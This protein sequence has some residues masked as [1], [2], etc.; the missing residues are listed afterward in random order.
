MPTQQEIT[1]CLK[2]WRDNPLQFH[3]SL[4]DRILW[5]KQVEVIES[6]RD[7]PRTVVKSG[8]TVGKTHISAEIVLWFLSTHY[9]AKVITTAPTWTQVE[10]ILWKEIASMYHKAKV[11]FGGDLLKTELKLSDDW[12][13]LGVST[14]EVN[15]FQGFHS[16]YLLVVIDEALGV[17]PMI[18]EAIEGLHPYRILAIGNP[19]EGVGNFYN[20]FQS[21][22]W[23]KITI[24]CEECVRWQKEN[25]VI[26]GLVTQVWIN[27]RAEDWG[28]GSPLFQSRVSGEF[29]EETAS[30]LISRAWIERAR[31]GLDL[32]GQ[33]IEDDEDTSLRVTAVDIASKHGECETVI[34]YRYGHTI[35][36]MKGYYRISMVE[37][38]DKLGHIYSTKKT[39]PPVIDADGLGEGL[40]E[41]LALSHIPSTEFHGGYGQK[42]IDYN[43][44]K[45]LR[46]Q[47]YC[48]VAKKFEKGM[49][50]LSQLPAKEYELLKNQLSSIR[51]KP[52]DGL[53]RLQIET[54]EDL[55]ARGIKSPDY[56]DDFVYLEYGF[57]MGRYGEIKAYSYR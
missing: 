3:T 57:W 31:K 48:M 21:S 27:D 42:A 52:P 5:D 7:N 13:A 14:N 36:E 23:N 16:P 44:Y 28:R 49:Y 46:T 17:S 40:P 32:D 39:Q 33:R 51:I 34:G 12:F 56:A 41:I 47:F 4:F 43:K 25:E 55:M 50:D 20:A 38:K 22:L 10:E 30:T 15:R 37:A 11:P 18:W 26:P 9:P 19:L 6:V 45:N 29:P 24:S 54:K 53:G 35:P 8:N 2:E 1:D